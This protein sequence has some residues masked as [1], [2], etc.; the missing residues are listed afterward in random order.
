MRSRPRALAI[1]AAMLMAALPAGAY[2]DDEDSPW[3]DSESNRVQLNAVRHVVRQLED[4][5]ELMQLSVARYAA[6]ETCIRGVPVSEYGDP[7][8]QFGYGYDERDGSGRSFM[9]ALA[10]DRK[11]APRPRGLSVPRLRALAHVPERGAEAGRDRRRR[12]CPPA[13]TRRAGRAAGT[14]LARIGAA[15]SPAPSRGGAA[16]GGV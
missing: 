15:R 4:K 16:G 13:P 6:W 8:R 9:P 5:V 7:D 2:A 1:A 14:V 12:V 3:P 10:V 11:R